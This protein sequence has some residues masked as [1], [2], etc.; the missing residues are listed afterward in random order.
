MKYRIVFLIVSLILLLPGSSWSVDEVIPQTGEL[1]VTQTDHFLPTPLGP[2]PVERSYYENRESGIL[3]PHWSIDIASSLERL[4]NNRIIVRQGYRKSILVQSDDKKHYKG[5]GGISAQADGDRWIVTST[6]NIT[7]IYNKNGQEVSRS[8]ANGNTVS[9][10]YDAQGRLFEIQAVENHPLSLIYNQ[11]GLLAALQV[12]SGRKSTYFYTGNG[13]LE[14]VKDPDNRETTYGYTKDGRLAEIHYPSGENVNYTYNDKGRV[15]ERSSSTGMVLSYTYGPSTKI[16]R[17][18]G[19]WWET[20]FGDNGLPLTYRDSL[21]R[22]QAWSWNSRGRLEKRTFLDGSTATYSYDELDRLT[23]LE[24]DRVDTLILQYEGTNDRPVKIDLNGALY[25]FTYDHKGNLHSAISPAGR[26]VSYLYDNHGRTTAGID[27]EGRTTGFE[28][29]TL[30]NLVKQDNPDGGVTTWKY[31]RNGRVTT[32]VDPLGNTT[33]Y[34]Y[35]SSG[36]LASITSPGGAR[37]AY[38][39]DNHGRL[40]QE[41]YGTFSIRYTY[42][43]RGMLSSIEYP[44]NISE[45]FTYDSLGNLVTHNNAAGRITQRKYDHAGRLIQIKLP[46]GLTLG[47]SYDQSGFPK[48]LS[49]GRSRFAVSQDK[50]DNVIVLKDPADVKTLLKRDNR[51][52]ITMKILPG[53]GQEQR[54]YDADGF[55]EAVVLPMGNV[56]RFSHNGAGELQ[57]ITYPF[58]PEGKQFTFSYDPAGRLASIKDPSGQLA[59][60][61]HNLAGMLI[62]STNAR[63]ERISYEYDRD[64]NMTRRRTPDADW[65]YTYDMMGNLTQAGNGS[66]TVRYSYDSMGRC[67]LVEYPEWKKSVTYS[68]DTLGRLTERTDPDGN[69]VRITYDEL[70]R[71]SAIEGHEGK[72]F[73]FSYDEADRLVRRKAPNGTTTNFVYDDSD[74]I[75]SITHADAVGTVVASRSYRYDAVGNVVAVKDSK[76][77]EKTY[78]YDCEQRL[79]EETG[80]S[81]TTKYVYSTGG[82]R[83]FIEKDSVSL[84]YRHDESGRLVKAGKDLFTYDADGNLIKR[85][86]NEGTIRYRYDA[87]N[88]LAEMKLPDGT[89]VKYGYGPFGERI[90]REENEKRQTYLFDGDNIFQVLTAAYNPLQTFIFAGLDRPLMGYG[91]DGMTVFHEDALGSIIAVSGDDGSVSAQYTYDAFGNIVQRDGSAANQPFL[92]TGRPFDPALQAYDLRARFYESAIG[93]FMSRDPVIGDIDDPVTLAPYLYA[94]NNPL[95]YVDHTGEK[96]K[97]ANPS[98]SDRVWDA[99]KKHGPTVSSG[100]AFVPKA[101]APVPLRADF[102]GTRSGVSIPAGTP[103]FYGR[104]SGG[105]SA[106]YTKGMVRRAIGAAR[107]YRTQVNLNPART[108]SQA[109]TLQTAGEIFGELTVPVVN[110]AIGEEP[111]V[112][113]A[114]EK[115]VKN[116]VEKGAPIAGVALAGKGLAMAFPKAAAALAPAA[117]VAIAAAVVIGTADRTIAAYDEGTRWGEAEKQFQTNLQKMKTQQARV[118]SH[119]ASVARNALGQMVGTIDEIKKRMLELTKERA[120]LEQQLKDQGS[121]K[122]KSVKNMFQKT[123]GPIE[124]RLPQM[125]ASLKNQNLVF[126]VIE[127]SIQVIEKMADEACE[128]LRKQGDQGI[129]FAKKK[130]EEAETE[131]GKL[132]KKMTPDS[133]YDSTIQTIDNLITEAAGKESDVNTVIDKAG[134]EIEWIKARVDRIWQ[135]YNEFQGLRTDVRKKQGDLMRH[136]TL[137]ETQLKTIKGDDGQPIYSAEDRAALE[138]FKRAAKAPL[139]DMGAPLSANEYMSG[140]DIEVAS[141]VLKKINA[142]KTKASD[143]KTKIEKQRELDRQLKERIDLAVARAK[144]C[145]S[146]E[147]PFAGTWSGT[148]TITKHSM[149]VGIGMS[150]QGVFTIKKSGAVYSIEGLGLTKV[151]LVTVSGNILKIEGMTR[152]TV[153]VDTPKGTVTVEEVEKETI[154]LQPGA[155]NRTLS[156]T[157]H[158][159]SI[160]D[161]RVEQWQEQ[162]IYATRQ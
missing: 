89:T 17:H 36:L 127:P 106:S 38:E 68:Y 92:F 161:G 104:P 142:F 39:Y 83:F 10:A 138:S 88:N 126:P 30:G 115:T 67:T 3:G 137:L 2:V 77:S 149:N 4:E 75:T 97:K 85:I 51:G 108:L 110:V 9:F 47:H 20:E 154:R 148:F 37:I 21:K 27:G 23:R 55:L 25:Q 64:G 12:S 57:T 33:G 58:Y 101:S 56:W 153:K 123:L 19:Y 70:G 125:D 102:L 16:T 28:Y 14:K 131:A 71:V 91:P 73:V 109:S 8:D 103:V 41:T 116:V 72:S 119:T 100:V 42:D 159:D 18:D 99:V 120:W 46:S 6:A 5:I 147:D 156:G 144:S 118:R 24:T 122:Q 130:A 146:R 53:G 1:T 7:S 48:Q 114:V 22:E 158:T 76:G 151:N 52:L 111:E 35:H 50:E 134:G 145:G 59:S 155:D 61:R 54:W 65:I 90:W 44:G 150:R 124:K 49:I 60:Y 129:E 32:E 105:V 84:M 93:R 141:G 63:G 81:E 121:E 26:K 82:D 87:E 112:G 152:T 107:T 29:D 45:Q 11:N 69:Q 80:P 128:M 13:Y 135:N 15:T 157:W 78:G 140:M 86:T 143:L 132:K 160:K 133:K 113:R 34:A 136:I 40:S 94:R 139:D 95:S 62:E 31:D 66:Y 117:P 74:R 96:P 43:T 162:S 98:R 79:T